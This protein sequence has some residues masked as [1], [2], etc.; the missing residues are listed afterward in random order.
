MPHLLLM[1]GNPAKVRRKAESINVRSA[2]DVYAH[3]IKAH[4]PDIEMSII[5]AADKDAALPE[6]MSYEDF[7]GMVISGSSLRAFDE[8]FAVQNQIKILKEFCET[9]K[10]V[11]GSCWGLQIAAIAAG[12]AVAAS[13]NGREIGFARK[14]T[15]T[16]AGK[17]HPYMKG[18]PTSFDAPCIHYDEVSALP[19]SATLLCSNKHSLVQGAVIPI[20]KSE[21]WAVQYHPEFDLEQLS[22]LFRLYKKDLLTQGFFDKEE[23][24][25]AYQALIDAAAENPNS[26]SQAWQLGI[27]EDILVPEN[28]RAEIIN[29]IKHQIL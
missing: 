14:V 15:L 8:T 6:G 25:S 4:F 9:G 29:W 16:E 18:K 28:R 20:G 27:D 3:A 2:S 19:S 26:K 1:E 23:D 10:P 21:V 24:V 5:Y 22:M 12:G 11:L 17:A 13:P 7:D